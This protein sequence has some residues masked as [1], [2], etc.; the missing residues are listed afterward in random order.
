MEDTQP[1]SRALYRWRNAPAVELFAIVVPGLCCC[2]VLAVLL[3]NSQPGALF[4][5]HLRLMLLVPK[6]ST[7]L[8]AESV[9][10][11]CVCVERAHSSIPIFALSLCTHTHTHTHKVILLFVL[12]GA[13]RVHFL[14]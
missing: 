13:G 5:P 2:L 4:P 7:E 10:S 8:V 11:V 9:C 1:C 3:S 12:W 6:S 14:H